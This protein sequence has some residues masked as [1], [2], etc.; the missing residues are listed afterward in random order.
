[1]KKLNNKKG[2]TIVELVIVI[3]VIGILAGVLIPTFAGV[4]DKANKS[5]AQQEAAN[6]LKVVLAEVADKGDDFSNA[7]FYILDSSDNI[8]YTVAYTN[9][10]LQEAKEPESAQNISDIIDT[11]N[12][13][14]YASENVNQKTPDVVIKD[15]PT[16]IVVVI[17]NAGA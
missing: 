5:A 10:E 12:D 15:L 16:T 3:A 7:T 14:F 8:E 1:M 6:A 17:T 11:E 2:F 13:V 9:G 4:I